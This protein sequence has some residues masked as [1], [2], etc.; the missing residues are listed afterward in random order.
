MRGMRQVDIEQWLRE[1]DEAHD[2]AIRM[3]EEGRPLPFVH[4]G[5][6][7]VDS[8]PMEPPVGYDPKPSLL[9]TVREMVK[10][11]LSERAEAEGYE[12][13]DDADNFDTGED[14][15]P[16]SGYEHPEDS[17]TVD[18]IRRRTEVFEREVRKRSR[19]AKSSPAAEATPP[20]AESESSAD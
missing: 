13:F 9:Q 15:F 17:P 6:T 4:R 18:E 11:D 16:V 19:K 2:E 20:T 14:D 1:R 3:I 10:R 5:R 8:T 7:Y 12:S